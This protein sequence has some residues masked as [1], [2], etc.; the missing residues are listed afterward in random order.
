MIDSRVEGRYPCDLHCHTTRSDGNDTPAELIDLASKI[1]M[2]TIAITDHDIGP[3]LEID[4]RPIA[5]YATARGV[6]V[7]LGYEFSCDTL[8]DDVH[9]CGYKMDWSAPELQAEVKAAAGSKSTGYRELCVRLTEIGMPVDWE[10]DILNFTDTS[11]QAAQRNED[12][13]QRKQIFEAMAT[14]GHA[15]TWSD[16][17]LMV[18]DNPKLNVRRRK[19]NPIDAIRLIHDCGGI[20]VLAHPYLIDEKINAPKRPATRREYIDRLIDASLDGIEARYTYDK[21][22]Y[23]G[24]MTPEQIEQEVREHFGDRISFFSAGSDYH[25]DAKKNAKR[26]RH[27]GERGLTIDEFEQTPLHY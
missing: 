16:A 15:E 13:V 27:L 10:S 26:V 3:P 9:I 18:R 25:A 19:I 22:S 2:N 11:G 24:T 20:A 23:S 14:L 7:I 1:G 4:G 12:E 17:K 5:E 8:V 6:R 21:T